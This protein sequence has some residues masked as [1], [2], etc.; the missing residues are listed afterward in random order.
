[1]LGVEPWE[2]QVAILEAM[3]REPRV[4]VRSCHGAGK[5][6]C[7]AWV[8]LW[9]LMSRPG[10][11]VVTTAPTMHQVKDLLWRRLRTAFAASKMKLPGRCLTTMLELDTEWYALG[12]ATDEEVNFQGPHSPHGVLQVGD[13]ASGLKEWIFHAME[14]TMTESG[15]KQFLIG[16]PNQAMGT[17][18]ESHR[19]W[20]ASQKFHISAFDVPEHVLRPDWKEDMLVTHGEESP[21]YQVRVLGNFPPQGEDSLFNLQWVEDA[22]ERESDDTAPVEIGVDVA[23]FGGDESVAYVRRGST[24]VASEFWRGMD[25]VAST[26]RVARLAREHGAAAIKVD[27]PGVGGGVTDQLKAQ[28]LPVVAVNVGETALDAENFYLKR[29][30]MFVGLRDRFKSGDISIPK[31]D[32]L[33]VDQLTSLRFSYTPRGQMKLESKDDLRKRRG[34]AGRW[35]SPDRADALA[36]CFWTNSRPFVMGA[37]A[38]GPRPRG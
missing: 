4:T 6:I 18:F 38:A 11:I 21:V 16:N 3:A 32:S 12:M 13:E 17:F 25:T 36:L 10:S 37:W 22:Q 2:K 27:D 23:R 7:A 29:T 31:D 19:R 5:T 14:G 8:C 9:F 34:T 35:A 15:A 1:M 33:L 28:G 26:G 20:S 24:I 30:E